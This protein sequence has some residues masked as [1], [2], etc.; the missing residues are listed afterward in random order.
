M[1]GWFRKASQPSEPSQPPSEIE[2]SREN[3]HLWPAYERLLD[4][5]KLVLTERAG[6]GTGMVRQLDE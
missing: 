6:Y 4:E 3:I 5:G 2:L 1:F